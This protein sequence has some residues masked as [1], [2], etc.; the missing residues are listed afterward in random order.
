MLTELT[1]YVYTVYIMVY[2][3]YKKSPLFWNGL[4][5]LVLSIVFLAFW[6]IDNRTLLG[7]PIWVKPIKFTIS[8]LFYSWTS[9]WILIVFLNKWKYKNA[10]EWSLT[11]TA[12]IEIVLI[13]IQAMRGVS[14]H[15]NISTPLNMAIFSIMGISISLFWLFHLWIL[16]K[17][18]RE[19]SIDSF[20]KRILGYGLGISAFGMIIGFFMTLPKPDQVQMME[21][22]VLYLSGSHSFGG[23]DGGAGISFFGWNKEYGDMRIAHFFGMHAMQ[24]FT[25]LAVLNKDSVKQSNKLLIDTLGV[26]TFTI[27]LLLT[28]Q[29]LMGLSLFLWNS[30]F[31]TFL[32]GL[33]LIFIIIFGTL[34]M[35]SFKF[36]SK[37]V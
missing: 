8:L 13:S 1:C 36:R 6:L 16:I 2:E 7:V 15:F 34:L 30:F 9:M 11:I 33:S 12:V 10:I 32:I 20:T 22:G 26:V 21:K 14:S 35:T 37:T 28:V 4:V 29:A 17:I 18:Y 31:S 19:N 23:P 24:I 3:N 27:T 5:N 25:V